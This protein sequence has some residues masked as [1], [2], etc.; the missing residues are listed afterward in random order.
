MSDGEGLTFLGRCGAGLR[1][2][3]DRPKAWEWQSF[4][5]RTQ[6]PRYR[7]RALAP[8]QPR[9][10]EL[11]PCDGGE[12]DGEAASVGGLAPRVLLFGFCRGTW[13]A[14]WSCGPDWAGWPRGTRWSGRSGNSGRT[15]RPSGTLGACIAFR[16][17]LTG[18]SGRSGWSFKAASE[19]Q[20]GNKRDCCHD[21]H[22]NPPPVIPL[23]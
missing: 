19:R 12:T 10:S 21:P 23:T 5:R 7:Q 17:G 22:K 20:A 1:L 15:R 14:F 16:T 2:V 9:L 18:W 3:S 13:I 4:P 6:G 8:W 11:N